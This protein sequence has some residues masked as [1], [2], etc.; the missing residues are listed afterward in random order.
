M[1]CRPLVGVVPHADL[2]RGD[3]HD[4]S[5]LGTRKEPFFPGVA[6]DRSR[7][8]KFVHAERKSVNRWMTAA[9]QQRSLKLTNRNKKNKHMNIYIYIHFFN[10][11]GKGSGPMLGSSDKGL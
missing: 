4:A 9:A 10:T 6:G 7:A 2:Q 8:H 5:H 1:G 11:T 3:P